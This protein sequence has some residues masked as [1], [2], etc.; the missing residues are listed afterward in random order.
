MLPRTG[1]EVTG[2]ALQIGFI[3][4][5]PLVAFGFVGKALDTRLGT[6]PWLALVAIL[7][8]IVSSSVWLYKKFKVLIEAVKSDT[9]D[10][11]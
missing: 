7:L 5:L 11:K 8:A 1:W 9:T 3:I 4:A 2:F 10:E 6:E